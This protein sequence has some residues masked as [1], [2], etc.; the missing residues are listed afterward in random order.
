MK[1]KAVDKLEG[2][3]I[4]NGRICLKERI[5]LKAPKVSVYIAYDNT[6]KKDVAVKVY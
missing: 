5:Y 2:V 6:L 1:S 3:T 4:L